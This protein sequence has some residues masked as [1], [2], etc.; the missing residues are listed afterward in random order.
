MMF[1]T[2]RR[3]YYVC[4]NLMF[5]SFVFSILCFSCWLETFLVKYFV[6]VY[7]NVC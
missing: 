3:N 2:V 1:S 6:E 4:W 5:F 7:L